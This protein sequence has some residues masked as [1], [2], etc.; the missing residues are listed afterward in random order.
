MNS[1]IG[2]LHRE[3]QLQGAAAFAICRAAP[4]ECSHTHIYKHWLDTGMH[5]SMHY[6]THHMHLRDDPR[7]LLDGACSVICV[8]FNYR[9]RSPEAA[10]GV[11]TYALGDDYHDT[12]RKRLKAVTE[13]MKGIF[14]GD[15][16][17][18]IDSAPI[19]ERYWA[20]K[21]G[22]ASLTANGNVAIPEAG[23][24]IFLTEILTTLS[25]EEG[26]HSLGTDSGSLQ[27]GTAGSTARHCSGCGKCRQACPTG[28]LL[29][30]GLVDARRCLNYLT[31]EH[32]GPW[33]GTQRNLA[34][35]PDGQPASLFGCDICQRACP[36]N[37][38]EN[39]P[40][41]PEFTPRPLFRGE[42]PVL[43]PVKIAQMS[44]EEFSA[45]FSKSPIKRAKL[46]GLKRN[47]LLP[48]GNDP[49]RLDEERQ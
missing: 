47:A 8:A 46:A 5:A 29:E 35:L 11:A 40:I 28:A 37:A 12:L 31:I 13:R 19:P 10:R 41:I 45:T 43:T 22:L 14:G 1:T 27:S 25:L 34:T 4:V 15:Y 49:I 24:M 39:P 7:L 48:P 20:V 2:F 33:S 30:N 42:I 9:Q 6:M 44:Q 21:S 17:I 38:G 26:R 16:R 23:S 32:R 36:L 3:L 18:C